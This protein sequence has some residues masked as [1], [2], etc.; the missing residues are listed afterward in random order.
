[1]T[2]TLGATEPQPTSRRTAGTSPAEA[3]RSCKLA[4]QSSHRRGEP[5]GG[6]T[7]TRANILKQTAPRPENAYGDDDRLVEL[8]AGIAPSRTGRQRAIPGQ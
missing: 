7:A 5:G 6:G 8:G 3:G 1:M 2:A 4:G